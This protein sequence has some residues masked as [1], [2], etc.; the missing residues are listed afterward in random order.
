MGQPGIIAYPVLIALDA[1]TGYLTSTYFPIPREGLV[2]SPYRQELSAAAGNGTETGGGEGVD[3]SKFTKVVE[4]KILKG[5]VAQGSPD[6]NPDAA[7]ASSGALVTWI[8]EDT[9]L[10]TATSGEDT[11]DPEVG[12]LFDSEFMAPDGKYSLPAA[13]IG[14]G[15]HAYHCTLHPYMKGTITVE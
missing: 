14:T 11:D 2:E 15:E 4:I 5:A 1:I 9:T 7:T 12:K 6:Y 13:D 3:E 10:H 8:N